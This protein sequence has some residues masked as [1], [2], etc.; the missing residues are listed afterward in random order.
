MDIHENS[1]EA[2]KTLDKAS[3]QELVLE[4]YHRY[5]LG[6]TDRDVKDLLGF[7]DMNTVR[8]RITEM[9]KEDRP[10]LEEKKKICDS[11]TGRNVRV[12]WLAGP[13]EQGELECG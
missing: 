5:P 2:F 8:P 9:I 3:R 13:R 12:V 6:L 1:L 7:N 4:C 11:V 10:R